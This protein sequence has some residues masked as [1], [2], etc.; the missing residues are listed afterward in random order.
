MPASPVAAATVTLANSN[1][2]TED[3]QVTVTA[4]GTTTTQR[5]LWVFVEQG[6]TA[7]EM[8]ASQQQARG[9]T[10]LVNDALVPLAVAAGMLYVGVV[11][12][13]VPSGRWRIGR[14]LGAIVPATLGAIWGWDLFRWGNYVVLPLLIFC[15]MAFSFLLQPEINRWLRRLPSCDVRR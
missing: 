9:A 11:A 5:S 1:D 7:C 10:R 13:G 15:I 3:K 8:T 2:P 12:W 4:S 6:G 14:Y